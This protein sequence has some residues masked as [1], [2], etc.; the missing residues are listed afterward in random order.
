MY[1]GKLLEEKALDMRHFNPN[2]VVEVAESCRAE[3]K[4]SRQRQILENFIEHA[5]AEAHGDYDALMA[6]CS[7]KRQSYTAYGAG[8]DYQASLPQSWDELVHHYRMFS[9]EI[10]CPERLKPNHCINFRRSSVA[11]ALIGPIDSSEGGYK[12]ELNLKA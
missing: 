1:I 5:R 9:I 7:R 12:P 3:M 6:S 2:N 4:S 11:G 10:H 8:E